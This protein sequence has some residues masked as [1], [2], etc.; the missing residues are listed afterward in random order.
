MPPMEISPEDRELL[1]KSKFSAWFDENFAEKFGDA[2]DGR[3]NEIAKLSGEGVSGTTTKN[4]D[5]GHKR[6]L[7]GVSLESVLGL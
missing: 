4:D 5:K 1:A 3:L 2:F 7:L 6:S